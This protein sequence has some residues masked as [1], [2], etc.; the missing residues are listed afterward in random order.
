MFSTIFR[1]MFS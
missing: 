1:S